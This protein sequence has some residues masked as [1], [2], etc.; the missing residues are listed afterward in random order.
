VGATDPV[1]NHVAGVEAVARLRATSGADVGLRVVGPAG[2]AE[3]EVRAAL[4][5]VDPAGVWTSREVDVP[6]ET[7]HAAY[8]S[9][10]VL[11]QPSH[12]EGFGLPLVEAAGHGL[13]SVHSGR[14]AMPTVMP[15]VNAGGVAPESLAAAMTPLLAVER[16]SAAAAVATERAR[17]FEPHVFHRTV[18]KHVLDLLPEAS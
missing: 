16:W 8:G 6:A 9:S 1:K 14:G 10:W 3:S 2:R 18:R 13:P 12:D 5:A 15:Q 17:A 7:L 4:A 11:L